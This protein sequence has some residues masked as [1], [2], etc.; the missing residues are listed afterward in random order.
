M[1]IRDRHKD[2]Q[3]DWQ[4][5]QLRYIFC[6]NMPHRKLRIAMRPKTSRQNTFVYTQDHKRCSELVPLGKSKL[7]CS[8]L[9]LLD[10]L[11]VDTYTSQNQRISTVA[12]CLHVRSPTSSVS[13]S[14]TVLRHTTISRP[15]LVNFLPKLFIDFKNSQLPIQQRITF[16]S[17]S[18]N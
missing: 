13:F 2:K 12:A 11:Y 16:Y 5:D 8:T 4:T 17:G 6:S 1:C 15:I 10:I 9:H 14:R 18:T 3:T 7:V